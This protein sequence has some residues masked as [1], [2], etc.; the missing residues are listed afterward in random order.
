MFAHIYDGITV[1]S[2]S[3]FTSFN[4]VQSPNA[5][6]P[7]YSS[8]LVTVLGIVI[9]LIAVSFMI[10]YPSDFTPSG[11]TSSLSNLHPE[12]ASFPIATTSIPSICGGITMLVALLSHPVIVT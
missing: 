12:K 9:L 11:I 3:N 10:Q 6:T 2:S 5:P 8:E 7:S 1:I 4:V